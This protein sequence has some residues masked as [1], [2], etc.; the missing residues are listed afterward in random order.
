MAGHANAKSTGLMTGA[1]SSRRWA[2]IKL[3]AWLICGTVIFHLRRNGVRLGWAVLLAP[4]PVPLWLLGASILFILTLGRLL[5][6][7][8]PKPSQKIASDL[9]LTVV[10]KPFERATPQS[11]VFFKSKL[12]IVLTNE[13][14][15]DID[16]LAPDWIAESSDVP[17]QLP[18]QNFCCL[19][20][21]DVGGWKAGKM[22]ARSG[23]ASRSTWRDLPRMD[24]S[25]PIDF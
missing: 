3:R 9:L 23:Q 1:T 22:E 5:Y 25:E 7:R 18:K 2:F 21:E 16:A 14:G 19:Q 6:R 4:L 11:T 24:R 8:G 12:R 13:T 15:N 20:L 17:L 10:D